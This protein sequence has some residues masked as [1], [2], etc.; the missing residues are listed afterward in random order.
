MGATVM[1]APVNLL[2]AAGVV[3]PLLLISCDGSGAPAR[4]PDLPVVAV[5]VQPLAGVVDRLL[6]TGVAELRV[7]V[8]PGASPHSFEPG[9]RQLAVI[10]GAAL[11]FEVGHPAFSWESNWLDGLLA[12]TDTDR[13]LLSEGCA[14]IEDDPHVWLDPDCLDRLAESAA[15]ALSASFPQ[16]ASEIRDRLSELRREIRA[17]DASIRSALADRK[18]RTFLVQHGAWGYFARAYGLV[19][20]AILSHESSGAGAARLAMVIDSAR[21]A[22][23]REVFVQPQLS[24]EASRMVAEE[25]GAGIRPLDPLGRDPLQT[26]RETAVAVLEATSP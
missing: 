9:M 13:V 26:L 2:I 18:G 8:P 3:L 17:E 14:W 10:Q 25:I 22:D 20:L 19:Q 23:I 5:T 7:L 21:A 1:S 12:G 15:A 16:H 4:A 6:P 24:T 11:I